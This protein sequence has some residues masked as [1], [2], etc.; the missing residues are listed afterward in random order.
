MA[1]LF[2][3]TYE[4]FTESVSYVDDTKGDFFKFKYDDDIAIVAKYD[5]AKRIVEEL[6]Y[7]GYGVNAIELHDPEMRGYDKEFVIS[8]YDGDIYVEPMFRE[9]DYLNL[10][11]TIVYVLENCSS[12]VISHC[13]SEKL[14]FVEIGESDNLVDDNEYDDDDD[15]VKYDGCNNNKIKIQSDDDMHGF[16]VTHSN[17]YGHS[18][19]SFYSTDLSLVNEMAKFFK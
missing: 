9:K 17:E 18:S 19:Y 11:E 5:D 10:H 13:K 2:Y 12:K 4:D 15:H 16:S 14:H 3:E 8:L 1:D 7:C 6:I